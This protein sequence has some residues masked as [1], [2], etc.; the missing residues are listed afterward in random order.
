[1]IVTGILKKLAVLELQL[2]LK[3]YMLN[4]MLNDPV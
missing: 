3:C 1:V 4:E 2:R